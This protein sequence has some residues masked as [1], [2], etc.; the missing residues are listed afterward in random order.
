MKRR[1]FLRLAAASAATPA[2]IASVDASDQSSQLPL[3]VTSYRLDRTAPLFDGKV[4]IKGVDASFTVGAIGDM[5]SRLRRTR[6]I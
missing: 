6:N 5:N 2:I 4:K 1:D 3:N